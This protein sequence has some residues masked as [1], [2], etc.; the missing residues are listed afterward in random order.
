MKKVIVLAALLSAALLALVRVH[1]F[2][3][4]QLSLVPVVTVPWNARFPHLASSPWVWITVRPHGCRITGKEAL[5]HAIASYPAELHIPNTIFLQQA[6][7]RDGNPGD[8]SA[9]C[10]YVVDFSGPSLGTVGHDGS[11]PADAS[12]WVVVVI[13]GVTGRVG[14]EIFEGW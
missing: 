5:R 10:S 8:G 12:E 1:T 3:N 11:P 9:A 7:L 6:G 4:A 2:R 13:N 14:N